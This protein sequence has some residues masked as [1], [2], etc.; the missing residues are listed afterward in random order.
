M[1]VSA[2]S[3]H[4]NMY[5]EECLQVFKFSPYQQINLCQYFWSVMYLLFLYHPFKW[6]FTA[7]RGILMPWW[8]VLLL[9][10]YFLKIPSVYAEW[11]TTSTWDNRVGLW[12]IVT[13]FLPLLYFLIFHEAE[14]KIGEISIFVWFIFSVSPLIALPWLFL[15][16]AVLRYLY[17][18][19]LLMLGSLILGLALSGPLEKLADWIVE[20]SE[21]LETEK[22]EEPEKPERPE[23]LP[24]RWAEFWKLVRAYLRAKKEKICPLIEIVD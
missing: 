14:K 16:G 6:F 15:N 23:K 5:K 3:W 13:L 1:K 21:E 9:A 12:V 19:F 8:L 10:I 18:D 7:R 17:Q 2:K 24:G 4:G 20:K 11:Q 22:P